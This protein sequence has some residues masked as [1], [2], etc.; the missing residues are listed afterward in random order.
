[1][2]RMNNLGLI[3][4]N[5]GV[6]L[7]DTTGTAKYA[8]ISTPTTGTFYPAFATSSTAKTQ[9]QMNVNS[10]L[11]YILEPYTDGI[12]KCKLFSGNLIGNAYGVHTTEKNL[13]NSSLTDLFYPTFSLGNGPQSYDK[14]LK[15]APISGNLTATNFIGDLSGNAYCIRTTEKNFTNSL[16][17]DLFYPTFSIGTGPQSY[18]K[19]LT[20][21]PMSGNLTATNFI[22]DLSG[23]A[24]CIS[25]TEKNFSNSSLTDLFYPTFSIGTGPQSYDK[26]L[27]Y[28]P[29]SGNLTAT[30]F[31]GDLSGT[32]SYATVCS[33]LANRILVLDK[34]LDDN[35]YYPTFLS[36]DTGTHAFDSRFIYNPW[37][38][39]LTAATFVGDLTGT[40][41]NATSADRATT[42]AKA[43][44]IEMNLTTSDTTEFYPTFS[45]GTGQQSY[46]SGF[47]FVP[48]T[49]FVTA[50]KFIGDFS[51]QATTA[52]KLVVTSESASTEFFPS[53]TNSDGRHSYNTNLKYVPS[54]GTLYA[55]RFIGDIV[56][57]STANIITNLN[58]TNTTYYPTFS[59]AGGIEK[60]YYNNTNFTFN[61]FYG[62]LTANIFRGTADYVTHTAKTGSIDSILYYPAFYDQSNKGQCY[63]TNFSY[64][65]TTKT[66]TATKFSGIFSG[67]ATT[68]TTAGSCTGNAA[69]ATNATTAGSCTGNA[70]TATNATNATYA[71]YANNVGTTNYSGHPNGTFYPTGV[72][73]VINGYKVLGVDA[74]FYYTVA[75]NIGTLVSGRFN[76]T[77]GADFAEYMKKRDNGTTFS[78]EPGDICG[79][80]KNGLLTN[81]FS[82][83]IHFCV[84]STSPCMIAKGTDPEYTE[85]IAFCGQ[86]PVNIFNCCVGDYII[87]TEQAD[88]KI[89]GISI[90]SISVT[91][92]QY[93]TSIG[94]V[95]RINDNGTAE[96]IVKI[97]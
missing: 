22:G 50:N 53:F 61:P 39:K 47:K 48:S 5:T 94:K 9:N 87:P 83:S 26:R 64:S 49:G 78:I 69:T 28:A 35:N 12:L 58:I 54:S 11:S 32:A 29:M 96:I 34:S 37:D 2:L 16:L 17:T 60:L 7:I 51:G 81:L 90:P 65:A 89:T 84:K 8:D 77:G 30:N 74:S 3:N 52:T 15:Y 79:I 95:I 68:A 4:T 73:S 1:M 46:N 72:E 21:A 80:D 63:D 23:N 31:I 75:S 88:G 14:S 6:N 57:T 27:T 41:T 97:V 44:G 86:I 56:A 59:V 85:A 70:A 25:T 40:A 10:G 20:Y 33:G 19:S 42:S 36:Q 62:I 67:T 71:T 18:D 76:A 92:E 13:Q 45:Q 38:S 55:T 91:F 24:Y 93:K 82:D 66:L 43:D